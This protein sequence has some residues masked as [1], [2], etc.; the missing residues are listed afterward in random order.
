MSYDGKYMWINKANVPNGTTN[1]HRVS[2]D[3]MTDENLSSKFTGQNHQM[4]VLPDETVAFYAYGQNGCDDIK[5]Y[6]PATGNVKTVANAQ[7]AHGASGACHV[8]A[9]EYSPTDDTYVFSDL[10]HDNITKIKRSD[11]ST[12]W[13]LGGSTS[14]FT[15]AGSSWSR[16]HGI[17]VLDTNKLVFFNNAGENGGSTAIEVLLDTGAMTATKPWTYTA[18]PAV[19]N[20]IMGD[21]QRLENGNTVVAYS[22][23]GLVHEVSATGQLLQSI[24]WASGGQFGYIQ[25]RMSL[26]GPPPR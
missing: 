4:T 11:G 25:K 23:K 15:G 10:E 12:V 20:D 26:Y 18:N 2:M 24:S 6:N 16:Q 19:R 9:I 5:E 13:V 3:G 7:T 21:V 14:D 22:T 8:N 1:V 17:D